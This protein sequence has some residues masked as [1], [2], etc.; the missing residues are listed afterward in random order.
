MADWKDFYED[1]RER[2]GQYLDSLDAKKRPREAVR[3]VP[4]PRVEF[5]PLC[6]GAFL[7]G[8]LAEH[9]RSVHG[10]Q[11][12]YLRVNG[13]IIRDLGWAEHGISELRLVQLGRQPSARWTGMI[14]FAT[15]TLQARRRSWRRR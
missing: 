3:T 5:C 12:I 2:R 13:R 14:V 7:E 4:S 15:F 11:H 6:H 9:I 8:G 1:N 10:P